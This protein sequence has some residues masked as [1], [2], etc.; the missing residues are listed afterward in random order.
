MT[1][2]ICITQCIHQG[3][4]F[5]HTA[6]AVGQVREHLACAFTCLL[7]G[8]SNV[9]LQHSAGSSV[10]CVTVALLL[11]RRASSWLDSAEEVGNL[12]ALNCL[13]DVLGRY[14]RSFSWRCLLR[15]GRGFLNRSGFLYLRFFLST[16]LSVNAGVTQLLL[17]LTR[18]EQRVHTCSIFFRCV[19][20]G[21]LRAKQVTLH[22]SGLALQPCNSLL[23][24]GK[25]LL[26]VLFRDGTGVLGSFT[27]RDTEAFSAAHGPVLVK[28]A[29]VQL[30]LD[31][32]ALLVQLVNLVS[33]FLPAQCRSALLTASCA[34][35]RAK[36]VALHGTSFAAFLISKRVNNRRAV[37]HGVLELLEECS[38][39][40]EARVIVHHLVEVA[41]DQLQTVTVFWCWT[42]QA[43]Q[44]QHLLSEFLV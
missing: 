17:Q 33:C 29:R 16:K 20:L 38:V 36:H 41:L 1:R 4:Q 10:L 27:A 42:L 39:F 11:S 34:L 12:L 3:T 2:S 7:P 8:F 5:V 30:A 13:W 21:G 23:N 18:L 40:D 37:K 32:F 44:V 15:S 25:R 14:V 22:G 35:E 28:P 43:H 6:D 19:W 9:V 26:Y 31:T 24:V